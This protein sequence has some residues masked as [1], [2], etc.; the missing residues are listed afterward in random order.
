MSEAS[1]VQQVAILDPFGQTEG[2]ARKYKVSYNPLHDIDMGRSGG[3]QD[4]LSLADS[5]ITSEQGNGAHFSETAETVVAGVLEAMM[6]KDHPADR[7][8][9]KLREKLLG[10]PDDLLAYLS[11]VE[12]KAGLARQAWAMMKNVGLEEWGSHNST[13][14]RNLKWLAT[15]EMQDHLEASPFSLYEAVQQGASIFIVLPPTKVSTYKAWMRVLVRTALNA[16]EALGFNQKSPQTLFILDEFPLLGHFQLIE[17]AAGYLAGYGIKLIPVIQNLTQ[18]T[19]N[20]EKNWEAIMGNQAATIG[21]GI[22]DKT[23]EEHFAGMLG[24]VMVWEE[25]FGFSSGTSSQDGFDRGRGSQCRHELQ[26]IT[27]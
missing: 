7:T 25:S 16:K 18:L 8:L 3:V 14:S 22:D 1:S 23:G 11:H 15:P 6:L 5:L 9:P 10:S 13:L 19:K 26:L 21:F 2:P 4:I 12:T 20:Y 27:A 17:D 24:K